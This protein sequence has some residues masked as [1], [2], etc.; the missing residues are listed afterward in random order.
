MERPLQVILVTEGDEAARQLTALLCSSTDLQIK[1]HTGGAVSGVG[2]RAEVLLVDCPTHEPANTLRLLALER[3]FPGAAA[4][5]LIPAAEAAEAATLDDELVYTVLDRDHLHPELLQRTI[6]HAARHRR[7]QA[8]AGRK[9]QQLEAL[10]HL[11]QAVASSL[12]LAEVLERV[13]S[14]TRPLLEAEGVSVLLLENSDELRFAAASGSSADLLLGLRIP[15][16]AGVAGEVLRS[17]SPLLITGDEGE[18]PIY[19]HVDQHSGYLTRSLLAAPIFLDHK[20]IGVIEAVHSQPRFFESGDL[21]LLQ[22]AAQWSAIAIGNAQQHERVRRRL[23]ESEAL[24]AISQALATTLE[25]DRV[26]HLIVESAQ[27]VIPH[28]VRAVIHLLDEERQALIAVA[29]IGL[30]EL[31]HPDFTMRPGEGI[32]GLVITEGKTINVQDTHNDP[33]YLPLGRATHLRSLM[34][35]PVQTGQ[36]RLGTI[37]VSSPAPHAFSPDDDRLLT[38]LGVQAALA[39]ENAR[40]YHDLERAL[41]HEKSMRSQLVHTEKLSSMGKMIA[42]VAHELNNPLQAIQNALYLV[43]MEENLET[44]AREDLQ[45]ALLEAERMAELINRLRSVY[46]PVT[47]DEFTPVSLNTIVDEVYRLIGTHLRH[48]RITFNLDALPELP[49]VPLIHDQIK[50]VVLNLCLNAVEAMPQG[51]RLTLRSGYNS[52]TEE[53]FLEVKDTGNGI[54]ANIMPF[55]FEPFTTTKESGT[56][57]G[58]AISYD[59]MRRHAGH[60]EVE[61]EPGQETKF[62]I[63]LPTELRADLRDLAAVRSESTGM[64]PFVNSG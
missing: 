32:A 23:Q 14:G 19:R 45:V 10:L 24:A 9:A 40:L 7:S 42:S 11:G 29:V 43:N 52:Q 16:H 12:T 63:R 26:L 60:I 1:L 47:G 18:D 36:K 27:Q 57:L 5:L 34:V 58:L 17:G 30:E 33:R 39:I 62:T 2:E 48:N 53:V 46:R 25:L 64:W 54:S 4:I 37:S 49:L 38:T 55:I 3:S 56:G 22:T 8:R 13:I 35:A 41:Q 6:R 31:G 50:Q 21:E 28:V 44:Q 51:G 20:V 15:A 59:I 61:S